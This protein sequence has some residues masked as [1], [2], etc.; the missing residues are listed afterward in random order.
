MS[1]T[2]REN[3]EAWLGHSVTESRGEPCPKCG[4]PLKTKVING[5]KDRYCEHC[6]PYTRR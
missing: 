4:G 1:N 3:F 2:A 6:G 5:K